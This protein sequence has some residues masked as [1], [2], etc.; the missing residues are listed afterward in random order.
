[1]H[2]PNDS[3]LYL[4]ITI[5]YIIWYNFVNNKSIEARRK[6][7]KSYINLIFN[8]HNI[9]TYKSPCTIKNIIWSQQQHH[10]YYVLTISTLH[11]T[12]QV[13]L[14]IY[15]ARILLHHHRLLRRLRRHLR[16]SRLHHRRPNHRRLSVCNY[17]RRHRRLYSCSSRSS[18]IWVSGWLCHRPP[19]Q[20]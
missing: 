13:I 8:H 9:I 14:T 18:I 5:Q 2:T 1:M 3:L 16:P 10:L 15:S 11:Q 19:R 17:Y 12:H 20:Y 6:V 4:L 7:H